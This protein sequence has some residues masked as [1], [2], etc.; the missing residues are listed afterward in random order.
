MFIFA[1]TW[2]ETNDAYYEGIWRMNKKPTSFNDDYI[3]G[4]QIKDLLSEKKNAPSFS[5]E[6]NGNI[7]PIIPKIEND[8]NVKKSRIELPFPYSYPKKPP[9]IFK[10]V[11]ML[12][13]VENHL[14]N[15]RLFILNSVKNNHICRICNHFI[16][17]KT[18]RIPYGKKNI[19]WPEGLRHYILEHNIIPSMVF[20]Q[21]IEK[22]YKKLQ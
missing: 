12:D 1:L 6:L 14:E 15:K 16:G 4:K 20:L 22:Y 10:F 18:Y 5:S 13:K 9:A 7:V 17:E 19:F 8:E 21:E 11:E 2:I 3:L